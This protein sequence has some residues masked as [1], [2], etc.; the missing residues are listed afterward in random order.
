MLI[1]DLEVGKFFFFFF[2]FSGKRSEITSNKDF[3]LYWHDA[4][5]I[6][7]NVDKYVYRQPELRP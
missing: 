5:I 2:F 1:S 4:E 6:I 3:T 7:I